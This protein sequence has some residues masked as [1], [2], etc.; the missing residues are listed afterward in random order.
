MRRLFTLSG[1]VCLSLMLLPACAPQPEQVAELEAMKAQAEAEEQNKKIARELFAL[2]DA[3]DFDGLNGLFSDD[4]VLSI[5]GL[6]ESLQKDM[7]F[8]LIKHTTQRFQTGYM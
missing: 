8:Q 6:D 4:F 1:V 5:P 7:L 3:Q 2:I